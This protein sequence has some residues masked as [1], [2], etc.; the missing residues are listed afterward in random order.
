MLVTGTV[1]ALRYEQRAMGSQR[2]N[3]V[4]LFEGG[5]KGVSEKVMLGLGFEA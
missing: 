3:E 1:C 2:K 5:L 4:N